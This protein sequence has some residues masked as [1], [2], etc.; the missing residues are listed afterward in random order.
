MAFL[1]CDLSPVVHDDHLRVTV[2]RPIRRYRDGGAAMATPSAQQRLR[3]REHRL[4][5]MRGD[6]PFTPM[7][8]SLDSFSDGCLQPRGQGVSD[9]LGQCVEA[10]CQRLRDRIPQLLGRGKAPGGRLPGIELRACIW[11]GDPWSQGIQPRCEQVQPLTEQRC[12]CTDVDDDAADASRH[13]LHSV[14]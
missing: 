11:R 7:I 4:I 6:P 2:D 9:L 1:V 14:V 13:L 10:R 8:G 12:R 5:D 3:Q